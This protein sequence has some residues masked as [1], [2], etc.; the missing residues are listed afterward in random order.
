MG[1]VKAFKNVQKFNKSLKYRPK[2][3]ALGRTIA[4]VFKGMIAG[5]LAGYAGRV[6]DVLIA[7]GKYAD[8]EG[9]FDRTTVGKLIDD[10][11]TLVER[12]V[13]KLIDAM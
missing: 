2:I 8:Y 5:F 12:K 7:V 9:A 1:G 10:G 4:G 11:I 6:G 3:P 13:H